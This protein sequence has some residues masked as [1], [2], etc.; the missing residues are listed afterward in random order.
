MFDGEDVSPRIVFA[1]L[2]LVE[3]R[4]RVIEGRVLIFPAGFED[5]SHGEDGN[6]DQGK[7]ANEKLDSRQME[8]HCVLLGMACSRT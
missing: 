7:A 6:D 4:A 1:V 5:L 2:V 8:V 3:L